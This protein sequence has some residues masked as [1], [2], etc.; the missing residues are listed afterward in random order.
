M[1][2]LRSVTAKDIAERCEGMQRI[3]GGA[4]NW[5][6]SELL[7]MLAIIVENQGRQL[8][9]LRAEHDAMSRRLEGV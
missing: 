4:F 9:Q 2:A 7:R 5:G 8:E 3:S 6:A 1:T